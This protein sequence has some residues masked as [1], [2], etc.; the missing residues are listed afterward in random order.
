MEAQHRYYRDPSSETVSKLEAEDTEALLGFL[1]NLNSAEGQEQLADSKVFERVIEIGLNTDNAAVAL[2]VSWILKDVSDPTRRAQG[3]QALLAMLS[4]TGNRSAYRDMIS[5]LG[6]WKAKEAVEPLLYLIEDRD[7]GE[8]AAEALEKIT[9]KRPSRGNA[10]EWRKLL[11]TQGGSIKTDFLK[12]LGDDDP[13]ALTQALSDLASNRYRSLW[14]DDDV[15]DA[16]IKASSNITTW[17]QANAYVL[18]MAANKD[19]PNAQKTLIAMARSAGDFETKKS[20]MDSLARSFPNGNTIGL[21]LDLLET[22]DR[23][24]RMT[25]TS[26]LYEITSANAPRRLK[27]KSDWL[28]YFSKHPSARWGKPDK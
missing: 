7:Y 14:T 2:N 27:T 10:E 6:K 23:R 5:L 9:G 3:T 8:I 19:K 21:L 25:A 17:A 18:V 28:E 16:L 26:L 4:R 12:R 15:Y 13:D 22:E 24:V 1:R 20:L 11:S